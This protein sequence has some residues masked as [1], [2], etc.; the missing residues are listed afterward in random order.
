MFTKVFLT[1]VERRLPHIKPK[2]GNDEHELSIHLYDSFI[3]LNPVRV[4]H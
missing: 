2:I 3:S 1:N 4:V